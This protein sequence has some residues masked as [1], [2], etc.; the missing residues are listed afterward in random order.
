[1]VS[2][3]P[4]ALLFREWR[5]QRLWLC[6]AAAIILVPVFWS[7]LSLSLWSVDAVMV[8]S[9]L[10]NV[11]AHLIYGQSSNWQ[12]DIKIVGNPVPNRL[13]AFVAVGL[14]V[15]VV[16]QERR[17]GAL[18]YMLSGPVRRADLL[19]VKYVLGLCCL[20][21][22]TILLWVTS[23][24]LD[25]SLGTWIPLSVLC[26]WFLVT[27]FTA[28]IWFGITLVTSTYRRWMRRGGLR[29]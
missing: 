24:I 13:N 14:A 4:K 9:Q 19:R 7:I 5:V 8:R 25:T 17:Q 12:P 16:G 29:V 3:F 28:L 22:V 18:W 11:L 26:D 10:W 20:V 27:V 6:L 21:V 1:M 23:Y 15:T 2:Y